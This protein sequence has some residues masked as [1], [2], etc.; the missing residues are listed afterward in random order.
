ME[1]FS[2]WG[3]VE[4]PPGRSGN[5]RLEHFHTPF[6]GMSVHTCRG[7]DGLKFGFAHFFIATIKS[8]K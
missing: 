7:R 3:E 8:P 1:G 5:E 4:L 6:L 2:G